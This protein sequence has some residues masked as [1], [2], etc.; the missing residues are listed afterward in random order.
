MKTKISRQ[1]GNEL[2][3]FSSEL[4]V[5][6]IFFNALDIKR[7]ASLTA[8][9]I[10]EREKKN[11]FSASFFIF[12]FFLRINLCTKTTVKWKTHNFFPSHHFFVNKIWFMTKYL[13]TGLIPC[14]DHFHIFIIGCWIFVFISI[15]MNPDEKFERIRKLPKKSKKVTKLK[16]SRIID[17][18]CLWQTLFSL[19]FFLSTRIYVT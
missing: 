6:K 2:R 1:S 8:C 3:S 13:T 7:Y 16:W 4:W 5:I 15:K 9:V 14:L 10:N 17:F 19:F 12:C 11:R 18:L